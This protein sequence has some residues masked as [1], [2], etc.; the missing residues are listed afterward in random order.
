[1]NVCKYLPR[2]KLRVDIC[3]DSGPFAWHAGRNI[4][5]GVGAWRILPS[6]NYEGYEKA[7]Q[8]GQ[9]ISGVVQR[10]RD[11]RLHGD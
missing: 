6:S 11:Q 3:V 10:V 7:R 5:G 8:P 1:M 4:Y 9:M 2:E